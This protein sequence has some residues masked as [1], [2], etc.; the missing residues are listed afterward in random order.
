[1]PAASSFPTQA[2]PAVSRLT[3]LLRSPAALLSVARPVPS[4]CSASPLRGGVGRIQARA[5]QAQQVGQRQ[6]GVAVAVARRRLV[7]ALCAPL[8]S[9]WQIPSGRLR[10]QCSGSH[11]RQFSSLIFPF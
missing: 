11:A 10:A 3:A 2:G 1:L 4:H 8:A 9:A 6:R 7:C 5:D